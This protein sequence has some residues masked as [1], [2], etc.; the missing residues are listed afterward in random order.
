MT[1]ITVAGPKDVSKF[2]PLGKVYNRSTKD[3]SIHIETFL[4]GSH[5]QVNPNGIL[6]SNTALPSPC[7]TTIG[8]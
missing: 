2:Q 1:R 4:V 8:R 3:G 6:D 7:A 5:Y